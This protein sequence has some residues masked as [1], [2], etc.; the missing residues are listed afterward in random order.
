MRL[1]HENCTDESQQSRCSY[2]SSMQQPPVPPA[3]A[4]EEV[5]LCGTS[6]TTSCTD[7]SQQSY[8][9]SMQQPPVSPAV[10]EVNIFGTY[11]TH[12]KSGTDESQQSK[13]S[14][15]QPPVS[16]AVAKEEV[17]FCGT[18]STTADSTEQV[19]SPIR[20]ERPPLPSRRCSTMSV[21]PES[22]H[23]E[24][25]QSKC[26]M[27]QPAVS[28]AVAKEELTLC[29]TSCATINSKLKVMHRVLQD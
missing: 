2:I 13:C 18:S 4:K 29:G 6:C 17:T 25:Q 3:V 16:P 26:S 14:I 22:G 23:D 12:F 24:G 10:S 21:K 11:T 20:P 1:K 27:Q 28:P 7:E 19:Q 9:S 8:I 5:T 15:Q